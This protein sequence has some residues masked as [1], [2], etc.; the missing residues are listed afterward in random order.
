MAFPRS[1]SSSTVS[2][3]NHNLEV[4]IFVEGEKPENPQKNPL[5]KDENQQQTQPTSDAG[6]GNRTWDTWVGGECS[7]HCTIPAPLICQRS[8]VII[9][10]RSR[11][12]ICQRS[13]VI[14]CQRSRVIICQRSRVIICQRSRVIICQR[15]RL[16]ICQRSRVIIC[17]RSRVIICQRSRVIICQRSRVIICRSHN[18]TQ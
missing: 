17:Q 5:S 1:G 8:R 18:K 15:S 13:R 16:I 10:Q 7:H 6:F 2:R 14:I 11:V 4:L 9:C 3:S 12:I